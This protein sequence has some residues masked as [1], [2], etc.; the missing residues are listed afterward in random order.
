MTRGRARAAITD[1][2]GASKVDATGIALVARFC[3]DGGTAGAAAGDAGEIAPGWTGF[4]AAGETA[5]D[6][7]TPQ[8]PTGRDDPLLLYFTSGTVSAAKMVEHRQHYGLGHVAT[9][10]FWHDLRPGDWH[11]TVT[12]TGWAK[13]AWGG[14]FGQFHE[15]ACVVQVALGRPDA[16]TVLGIL[17][18]HA[19]TSFCAPADALPAAGAGGLLGFRPR[20]A[21]PLHQRRRAAQPR[22]NPVVAGIDRADHLRRLRADRDDRARR[23]LPHAAGPPRVDGQA[24]ARLGD[25][26]GRRRGRTGRDRRGGQRRGG[27]RPADRR[28]V[29]GYDG[30]PAATESVFRGP[31]YF[32]GDKAARDEDGYLWFEGRN[33][34]VITSSAYR[35]GPF[36]VESALVAH[37]AVMEAA[38]VGRADAQR[39]Q[40]VVGICIL[41]PGH[42]PSAELARELQEFVKQQ[43]APYKYPREIHFVDAPAQ[44][45]QRQDPPHRAARVAHRRAAARGRRGRLAAPVPMGALG[46]VNGAARDG[47][48]APGGAL[49]DGEDNR[50]PVVA[51]Q[52]SPAVGVERDRHRLGLTA[53]ERRARGA[54]GQLVV[55]LPGPSGPG[56]PAHR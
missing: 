24:G 44:D 30:D 47:P 38:V 49:H 16:S 21:A 36:E 20:G 5:G 56:R 40:I 14:L 39:T 55:A 26:R 33:D 2:A 7:D 17:E 51:C 13:A 19:I 53:P 11:W 6:G 45:G 1:P 29:P 18:R 34:D 28:P 54:D 31:H 35:I 46:E 4:R 48:R 12:D 32:T 15:R 27:H 43:T 10:R 25:R 37:P 23:Q 3:V 52:Q 9:A 22:G 50:E 42:V 41:A 8:D